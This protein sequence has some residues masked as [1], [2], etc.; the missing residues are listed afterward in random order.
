MPPKPVHAREDRNDAPVQP[1]PCRLPNPATHD[2][3]HQRVAESGVHHGAVLGNPDQAAHLCLVDGIV[4]GQFAERINVQWLAQRQQFQCVDHVVSR[5]VEPGFQE[6][7]QPRRNG[8]WSAQLPD[9]VDFGQGASVDRSFHQV[10]QEQRIAAGGLPHQVGRQALERSADDRF[11]QGN[12][13]LLV[14]RLQLKPLQ[15][16]VFPKRGDRIGNRFTAADRREDAPCVVDG[17]LMHQCRGQ[18][19]QQVCVIDP[20]DRVLLRDKGF[21][22]RGQER[23]GIARRGLPDEMG[24]YAEGDASGGFG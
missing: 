13:L 19:I 4:T 16:T 7:R 5:L 11:D 20:Y 18:L 3:A 22:R 14:E 10:A 2:I 23:R 8:G 21:P 9:V 24:E 17:D 12:A 1:A 15:V 6:R